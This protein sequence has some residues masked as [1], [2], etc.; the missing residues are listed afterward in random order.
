[1]GNLKRFLAMTLTMLMVVGCFASTLS[2]SAFDDVVDYQKQ[3]NLMSVL[4]IIEGY[5]E[6]EFGPANDVERWHMALWIAKI[7]TGK[8]EDAYVNWYSTQNNTAFADLEVDH[9]FGSVSYCNEN[10][11][12]IGTSDV[13]F[14]PAKGIMIQDVFTMVVRM[15]GYGSS[16]MDAN[17]PWSYVDKAIQLS[18]DAD[19]AADYNNEDVATREQA[20]VILYNALF[21]KKADGTTFAASKFNLTM[22]TIVLTGSSKANMYASGDVEAKTLAKE[23][24]VAF[25]QLDTVTGIM[26][27]ETF[28]L[29]KSWFGFDDETDENLFFGQSYKVI[30]KDNYTTLIYCEA[31]EG[32]WLDQTEFDGV[33][34][35]DND[36]KVE[37]LSYK[38]V[39]KFSFLNYGQGSK[40]ND[41]L[42]VIVYDV[43]NRKIVNDVTSYIMDKDRNI[44]KANGKDVALYYMP[45]GIN[46]TQ[47]SAANSSWKDEYKKQIKVE[48]VDVYVTPAQGDWDGLALHVHS[49]HTGAMRKLGSD[50]KTGKMFAEYNAYS[51]T[52][53]YDDNFD[54]IYDRAMYRYYSFGFISTND[55]GHLTMNGNKMFGDTKYDDAS[56]TYVTA[57]G[58]VLAAADVIKALDSSLKKGNYVLYSYNPANRYV[59]IKEF[60]TPNQGLVTGLDKPNGTI[61]F[62]QVYYNITAGN[63]AGTKFAVG[64]GKLPGATKN[65][66]IAKIPNGNLDQLMGRNVHY[67]EKDGAVLA[68]YE[69]YNNSGKY[70]VYDR[71]VGINST[72]YVN[73]LV[74]LSNTRSVI[75]IA[76]LEGDWYGT[77]KTA[78]ISNADFFSN[79][80]YGELFSYTTDALGNYHVTWI[81]PD[82]DYTYYYSARTHS[83]FQN[84]SLKF[85]NGISIPVINNADVDGIAEYKFFENSKGVAKAFTQFNT[86]NDTVI[87]IMNRDGDTLHA[88][89]GVPVNNA[90]IDIFKELVDDV[91]VSVKIFVDQTNEKDKASFAKFIYIR[92]AR[93]TT[94]GIST[95]MWDYLSNDT[96]IFVDDTAAATEIITN[97]TSTGYGVTLGTLYSYNRTID[98]VYGGEKND[99]LV[100]NNRLTAG[101]FYIVKDGYV[102]SGKLDKTTSSEIGVAFLQYIDTYEAV[103]K[104]DGRAMADKSNYQTNYLYQLKGTD[105]VDVSA[106]DKAPAN[107]IWSEKANINTDGAF[108]PAYYYTGSI[109]SP[110]NVFIYETITKGIVANPNHTRYDWITTENIITT[111]ANRGWG[112]QVL[113][114]DYSFS[115]ATTA[116]S[117][118]NWFEITL[119]EYNS[120]SS[121]GFMANDAFNNVLNVFSQGVAM[122]L[123]DAKGVK[124]PNFDAANI[125]VFTEIAYT[126]GGGYKYFIVFT[127]NPSWN[128]NN[129]G[130]STTAKYTLRWADGITYKSIELTGFGVAKANY[131]YLFD[132]LWTTYEATRDNSGEKT[133][134]ENYLAANYPVELTANFFDAKN[135]DNLFFNYEATLDFWGA[136]VVNGVHNVSEF[137]NIFLSQ[138]ALLTWDG[139]DVYV[140]VPVREGY[141]VKVE[142]LNLFNPVTDGTNRGF[143]PLNAWVQHW[144][145]DTKW[146]TLTATTSLHPT[147]YSVYKLTTSDDVAIRVIYTKNNAKLDAVA[148]TLNNDDLAGKLWYYNGT[149]IPTTEVKVGDMFTAGQTYR[150]VYIPTNGDVTGASLK[151]DYK[152]A[153]DGFI[154]TPG[155][156]T[157]AGTITS[158]GTAFILD[159]KIPA[160]IALWAEDN[161]KFKVIEVPAKPEPTPDPI[162]VPFQLHI[163]DSANA[164]LAAGVGELWVNGVKVADNNE[165][166]S[167]EVGTVLNI[168]YRLYSTLDDTKALQIR[169]PY[170]VT[171]NEAYFSYDLD[172]TGPTGKPSNGDMVF[173][174]TYTVIER[175]TTGIVIKLP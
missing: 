157:F 156:A 107:K 2:V 35:K 11:V 39:D 172:I 169:V 90:T 6:D 148:L 97:Q 50:L 118:Y 20:A 138:K 161:L 12:V 72:G 92:A 167:F 75:T 55:D 59:M 19:L 3:I 132:N 10:G 170:K 147:M 25:N 134:F 73:A 52:V 119:D 66:V 89:K 34:D 74:Y 142:Y 143:M 163:T 168:T 140:K 26:G 100:Y 125:L 22:D 61:T 135:P 70:F 33:K 124:V 110:A 105:I 17:Y 63:V 130:G 82:E 153:T 81:N 48:G 41:E 54:G 126:N 116:Y 164:T 114:Q 69:A 57:A 113:L 111:R 149:L 117:P 136:T 98:F 131:A 141:T 146:T 123:L 87:I 85:I 96:V 133:A 93:F 24:Y 145:I 15:L 88:F 16:S 14:E 174:F 109:D 4:K 68:I 84:V 150:L 62:D 137:P 128:N 151:L 46:G 13:T 121:A 9:F 32:V 78:Y 18:L 144:D 65:E 67:I 80:A 103:W 28:Y 8:V 175:A 49:S 94:F 115:P 45:A 21:A 58:E 44:L 7:M 120:L 173:S 37:G 60:F 159:V 42:E 101:N 27:S 127:S 108:A 104:I 158:G 162:L 30:T 95:K 122:E 83:R 171:G 29:L 40:T 86:N 71:I 47:S 154:T 155:T 64:N 5:S 79:N 38:A 56:I 112:T 139:E 129:V 1:M 91:N 51:D 166:L 99:I 77:D 31:I 43:N 165:L 160:D 23:N 76:S 53:L 106:D 102:D 152:K 36:L